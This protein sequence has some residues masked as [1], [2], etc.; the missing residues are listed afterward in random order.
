MARTSRPATGYATDLT[1]PAPG[2]GGVAGWTAWIERLLNSVM[3]II[4]VDPAYPVTL[5][6]DTF[7]PDYAGVYVISSEGGDPNPD[8]LATIGIT[9]VADGQRIAVRAA[10]ATQAITIVHGSSGVGEIELAAGANLVLSDVTMELTL[11]FRTAT[12]RWHEV[13][14]TFGGAKS[15]F[16]TYW[17]LAIGSAVQAF[18]ANLAALAGLTGA[19]DKFAIF[20][21][22][23]AMAL[24]DYRAIGE[25]LFSANKNNV[26]QTAIPASTET[27]LTFGTEEVDI[28]SCY[29]AATSVFTPNI[30]GQYLFTARAAFSGVNIVADAQYYLALYKNGSVAKYGLQQR[31]TGTSS[32]V[33]DL[34]V[35]VPANGTTDYFELYIFGGGAGDKTVLGTIASTWFQA[36]KVG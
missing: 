30:A 5:A 36:C 26:N 10:S 13:G 32:L 29:N 23:G 35:S 25:I 28:G 2:G 4:G 8:N 22:A 6:S 31:S 11:E 33:V 14:F 24:R 18:H 15:A 17:G 12:Q 3:Q 16:R 27:K 9:D 21:G 34:N 20:T 19:A 7:T 1:A